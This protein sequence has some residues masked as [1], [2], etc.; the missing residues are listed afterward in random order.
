MNGVGIGSL[1]RVLSKNS[2]MALPK[3][4]SYKVLAA[5]A[6]SLI[7][8]PCAIVVGYISFVMTEALIEADNPGGGM[9]FEMQVL[10]AFSMIFGMICPKMICPPFLPFNLAAV[11]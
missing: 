11:I 4:T 7:M 2:E 1:I 5:V 3:K 8:I 10:S 9:L 6:V